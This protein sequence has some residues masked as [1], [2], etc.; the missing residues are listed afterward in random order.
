MPPDLK[1]ARVYFSMLGSEEDRV[2]AGEALRR[3]AGFLR[4]EVGQRCGLRYAPELHF[5]DDR[6]LERGARVEEL[7]AQVLP[8]EKRSLE[9]PPRR[10]KAR[11]PL[12]HRQAGGLTSHDVVERVRK[13]T[14]VKRVGHS[15]TLD[16]MATGPAAALRR[17]RGAPAGLLHEARQVLRGPDP[18]R[19]RDDDVRPGGRGRR[20]GPRRLAASAAADRGGRRGLPRRVPAVPSRLL[21]QEGRR[22]E[23]LRDGAQGRERAVAAQDGPTSRSSTFGPLEA[24]RLP[25]SIACTS[26][27]YV[28]SIAHDLGEKLG[29]GAHLETLRRTRIGLV[30]SRRRRH[31]RAVRGVP[32]EAAASRRPT[33]SRSSASRSPSSGCSSPSWKPGRSARA[34]RS[35]PAGSPHGTGTGS[36]CSDPPRKWWPSARSAAAHEDQP[37]QA[38]D[39][40]GRLAWSRG[41][42]ARR[43]SVVGWAF[44]EKSERRAY[45]G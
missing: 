24:A 13:A 36:P 32:D 28:R 29:C 30:R 15:G 43:E 41:L 1:S 3:A 19:P 8:P 16:P 33:R 11:V 34:R 6:S 5:V 23:V 25:F 26:G 12:P 38:P 42:T 31:P 2:A 27:T 18:A 21:R 9:A 39:R 22:A 17:R 14:G 35:R 4:R 10:V 20:R 37:A 40:P 44:V 45:G 7:L